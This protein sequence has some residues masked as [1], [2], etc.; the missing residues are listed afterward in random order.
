MSDMLPETS[1]LATGRSDGGYWAAAH[2]P[3]PDRDLIEDHARVQALRWERA[4]SYRSVN[5]ASWLN[6]YMT[7]FRQGYE[8]PRH[9][10]MPWV[11]LPEDNRK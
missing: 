10:F 9:R 6:N 3:F 1:A 8:T 2:K 4:K 7:G 5:G 11:D